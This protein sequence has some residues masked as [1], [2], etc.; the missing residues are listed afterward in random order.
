MDAV[1]LNLQ[2]ISQCSVLWSDGNMTLLCV[3]VCVLPLIMTN[4][5][6]LA[7]PP[8]SLTVASVFCIFVLPLSMTKYSLSHTPT[9]ARTHSRKLVWQTYFSLK[10]V[11]SARGN[12]SPTHMPLL[13]IKGSGTH[14]PHTF[15]DVIWFIS[16][17]EDTHAH[18]HSQIC[19]FITVIFYNTE[20]MPERRVRMEGMPCVIGAFILKVVPK[21][22]SFLVLNKFLL[23]FCCF[24]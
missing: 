16:H 2:D 24:F 8:L 15:F 19:S 14:I 3:C 1:W 22:I 6:F 12:L 11:I 10:V 13:P 17:N 9:C 21:I 20:T 23:F 4:L 7:L 18:R 5:S